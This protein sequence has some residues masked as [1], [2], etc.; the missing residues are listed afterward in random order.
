[1]KV[2]KGS[3]FGLQRALSPTRWNPHL[4][5]LPLLEA[6]QLPHD[7]VRALLQRPIQRVPRTGNQGRAL[8]PI[9]DTRTPFRPAQM[10]A[11]QLPVHF[12]WC[13]S[14]RCKHAS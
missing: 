14:A 1:M 13:S 9:E 8:D 5:V 7:P 11:S 10:I 6:R 3:D 4:L 2:G 12:G